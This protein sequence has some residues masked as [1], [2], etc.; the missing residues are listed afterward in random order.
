MPPPMNLPA[1]EY[2]RNALVNFAPI[3]DAID[4]N[5]ADALANRRVNM[6]GE[7][8]AM[9][10]TRLGMEQQRF[11]EQQQETI[12]QRF[13]NAAMLTLAEKDPNKRAENWSKV[14]Q[15][16]P[17]AA[18]L[19][20]KYHDPLTGPLAVLADARMA[21]H[22]LDYQ[23]RKASEER[24]AAAESRAAGLYPYQKQLAET[25][26]LIKKRELESPIGSLMKVKDAEGNEIL[27]R[28]PKREGETASVVYQPQGNGSSQPRIV[29]PKKRAEAEHT[30]RTEVAKEANDYKTVRD[31]AAA[32]E[33]IAKNPSAASDIALIFSYMKILDPNSVVRES[34]FATAQ[35]ATGVPDRVRNIYNR[36]LNGERLNPEQRTDFLKQARAISTK[37]FGQYQRRIDQYR[38]VAERTGVD[39]RN[40]ILD[41][42]LLSPRGQVATGNATVGTDLNGAEP[43]VMTP[44]EVATLPPGA[45]FKTTDG[46]I[47]RRR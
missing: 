24:A 17:G 32:L 29:D 18:S 36:V 13:G 19:D 10:R 21:Q 9:D 39:W 45:W 8:L 43:P 38:G 41:Q 34:E 31:A 27:I 16:H 46:R 5:R 25:E 1:Y 3:N 11:N 23:I 28:A 42:D 14:I 37:H 6:E 44:E 2:P 47:M 22:Y 4:S 15:T 35:N 33:G 20:P 30:L 7:R 26:A 12:K 40:V